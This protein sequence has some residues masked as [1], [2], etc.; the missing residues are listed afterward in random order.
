MTFMGINRPFKLGLILVWPLLVLIGYLV[1]NKEPF[2][3]TKPS[4]ESVNVWSFT[5][6]L[7]LGSSKI[8][9]DTSTLKQNTRFT[10]TL[11]SGYQYPY[12]GINFLMNT[13][14]LPDLR[15]YN[16]VQIKI[17]A[18]QGSRLPIVIGLWQGENIKPNGS[19]FMEYILPVNKE[20]NTVDVDFSDFRTPEWW[21]KTN[22]IKEKELST[23]D[24]SKMR[25]LNV[26]SC[27]ILGNNVEDIIE[28]EEVSLRVDMTYF[29]LV[30]SLLSIFYYSALMFLMFG[31]KGK[32][33]VV[34]S[35]IKTETINHS[36][37]EEETVF[38][39]ITSHYEQQSLSIVDIQNGTGISEAKISTIIKNK[40]GLTFK[41]FLN[42]LRLTES[43]RLLLETDLQISEIAYKVGYSN[44]SHFNR[45]FKEV[46]L[47]TPNDFRK[48]ASV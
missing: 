3:L 35:Y 30:S 8:N 37:K 18:T 9:F 46:E 4:N 13:D 41:Q 6:T 36:V 17:K 5:D 34:F 32:Q 45:I 21:L 19:R 48:Q 31:K 22:G 47:C 25:F 42:K 20:W 15:K 16:Y 39:F 44:V 33:S 29:Y 27:Q 2:I 10:Y 11:K 40:S 14:S 12:V 43:K 26:Q 23:P 24:F 28:I 7:D 1:F 38:A